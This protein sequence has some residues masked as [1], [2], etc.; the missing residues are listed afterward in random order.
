MFKICLLSVLTSSVSSSSKG[1]LPPLIQKEDTDIQV[2]DSTAVSRGRSRSKDEVSGRY[3][4]YNDQLHSASEKLHFQERE[5]DVRSIRMSMQLLGVWKRRDQKT[6]PRYL[7]VF[8]HQSGRSSIPQRLMITSFQKTGNI[9]GQST[10]KADTKF[11]A[12]LPRTGPFAG[13]PPPEFKIVDQLPVNL[14]PMHASVSARESLQTPT[15]PNLDEAVD[16]RSLTFASTISSVH[17]KSPQ[18][19]EVENKSLEREL[20]GLD[21][22]TVPSGV[23]CD[24]HEQTTQELGDANSGL[25]EIEKVQDPEWDL[26]HHELERALLLAEEKKNRLKIVIN[27]QEVVITKMNDQIKEL[28][29]SEGILRSERNKFRQERNEEQRQMILIRE[30]RL[31]EQE[32]CAEIQKE[33]VTANSEIEKLKEMNKSPVKS[34][35]E[36]E[37][38][39]QR[40]NE[41]LYR[42]VTVQGKEIQKLQHLQ[43]NLVSAEQDKITL[44]DEIGNMVEIIKGLQQ[45]Q[46]AIEDDRH[47]IDDTKRKLVDQIAAAGQENQRVNHLIKV[48]WKNK[49]QSKDTIDSQQST[50]STMSEQIKTLESSLSRIQSE[51]HKLLDSQRA[52]EEQITTCLAQRDCAAAALDESKKECDQ[53]RGSV[54][55][56]HERNSVLETER[57][58]AENETRRS[59]MIWCCVSVTVG[60]LLMVSILIFCIYHRRR[61]QAEKMEI[62]R[63]RRVNSINKKNQKDDVIIDTFRGTN[64]LDSDREDDKE[65]DSPKQEEKKM[66]LANLKYGESLND[67]VRNL[68]E[69]QGVLMDDIMDEMVTAGAEDSENVEEQLREDSSGDDHVATSEVSQDCENTPMSQSQHPHCIIFP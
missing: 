5:F 16:A 60:T 38:E 61:L 34:P 19:S 63:L 7:L 6:S 32:R 12:A 41:E 25:K 2:D 53:L 36:N 3:Q 52:Q 30:A 20:T 35:I 68:D 24:Y 14:P 13:K 31:S 62:Y 22:Q 27:S 29:K 58:S 8:A 57:N 39:M 9:L 40:K 21:V 64:I 17:N 15:E 10:I 50:I 56:A 48:Q 23:S 66:P 59:Q 1:R 4:Y 11:D 54:Q 55:A 45:S 65:P 47:R 42:L 67:L 28:Q 43:G 51:R 33:L 44:N 69:V 26:Y 46:S 18:G 49:R 37:S